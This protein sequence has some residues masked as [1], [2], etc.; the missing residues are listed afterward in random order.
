[1]EVD[2]KKNGRRPQ[3]IKLEDNPPKKKE[4]D[5]KNGGKGMTTSKKEKTFLGVGSA[6]YDFFIFIISL[7]FSTTNV[8]L[9]HYN[10]WARSSLHNLYCAQ[11][12]P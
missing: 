12:V 3:K 6:L 5:K 10:G 8:I 1:M 9:T 4:K 11:S 2:L 7:C